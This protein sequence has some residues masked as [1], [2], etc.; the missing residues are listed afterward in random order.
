MPLHA[1]RPVRILVLVSTLLVVGAPASTLSRIDFAT[2]TGAFTID[3]NQVDF[4]SDLVITEARDNADV[5]DPSVIGLSVTLDPVLLTG[6]TMSFGTVTFYQVDLSQPYTLTLHGIGGGAA[7]TAVFDP[8]EFIVVGATGV[9]SPSTSDGLA[10]VTNG[11]PGAHAAYDAIAAGTAWDW[12]ASFSAAG[13][14]VH[15]LL[16]SG[17]A[18]HGAVAGSLSVVT[19][20]IVPEPRAHVLLSLGLLGLARLGRRRGRAAAGGR[21]G[22]A[23]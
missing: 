20:V 14:D 3:A 10:S 21:R 5:A 11:A 13:Q 1:V 9:L 6:I 23:R 18:A 22:D 16:Q 2:R 4:G 15:A 19:P 8:G 7:V 17:H 12:S